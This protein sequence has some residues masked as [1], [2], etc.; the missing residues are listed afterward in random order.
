MRRNS[1]LEANWPGPAVCSFPGCDQ[2]TYPN[3][4]A[5]LCREHIAQRS[6][7]WAEQHRRAIEDTRRDRKWLKT[8]L[9][10]CIA[11]GNTQEVAYSDDS[12]RALYIAYVQNTDVRILFT[13]GSH[14]RPWDVSPAPHLI[15]HYSELAVKRWLARHK[16][17]VR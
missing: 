4:R 2:S 13:S 10:K 1:G 15:G 7:V 3:N 6:R 9:A 12:D 11:D 16:V 8:Q 14:S 17:G 5:S